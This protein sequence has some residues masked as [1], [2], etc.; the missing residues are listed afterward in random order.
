M[1]HVT[2]TVDLPTVIRHA[3]RRAREKAGLKPT[4]VGRRMAALG[5]DWHPQTVFNVEAGR[6]RVLAEE[7]LPLALCLQTPVSYLLSPYGGRHDAPTVQLKGGGRILASVAQAWIGDGR[8]EKWLAWAD[9]EPVWFDEETFA[10]LADLDTQMGKVAGELEQARGEWLEALQTD[11]DHQG[12]RPPRAPE[13]QERIENLQGIYGELVVESMELRR[14]A[15][16]QV[17]DQR[18]EER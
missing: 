11:Q 13:L 15:H 7:L 18:G 10:R 16:P 8:A 3:I 14:A 6:R 12:L 17:Q 2:Q 9:D 4:A 1:A 5:Y